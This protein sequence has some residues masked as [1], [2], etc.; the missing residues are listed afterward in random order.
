MKQ[1]LVGLACGAA[2]TAAAGCTKA[3][4]VPCTD[5]VMCDFL[6]DGTCR[7]NPATGT[8]WCA[9][10]DTAC[11]SGLRWDSDYV[12]D[13]VAG[14][15][16]PEDVGPTCPGRLAW[17]STRD[18]NPDV[19][20]GNDDGSDQQNLTHSAEQED[21]PRWSHDGSMIAYVKVV[22]AGGQGIWVIGADGS[23]PTPVTAGSQ[24]SEPRWSPDDSKIAFIRKVPSVVRFEVWV[25]AVGSGSGV[26][27][28]VTLDDN[29]SDYAAAWSPDGAQLAVVSKTDNVPDLVVMSADGLGRQNLSDDG[30]VDGEFTSPVWSPDGLR[31]MYVSAS[32]GDREIWSVLAN[33]GEKSNLSQSPS[34]SDDG[35]PDCGSPMWAPDGSKIYFVRSRTSAPFQESLY[36]MNP[37][38]SGQSDLGLLAYQAASAGFDQWPALAPKGD[39]VAWMSV[40]DAPDASNP[41]YEIYV[42]G[43]HGGAPTRVTNTMGNSYPD[44]RPCPE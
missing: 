1:V 13:N 30:A 32:T 40:R 27:V 19:F 11:P 21:D 22:P 37:D 36:E 3:R 20:V 10:P 31:V 42:A 8:G 12:G 23:A 15:C 5:D 7:E 2:V 41:F 6:P 29:S 38:G 34:T 17:I 33:G 4:A 35:C 24:D 44:W 28:K 16:V 9:A 43:L 26:P 25:V 14:E 39:R 18:G